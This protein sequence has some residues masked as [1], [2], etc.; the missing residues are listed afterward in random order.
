MS[1]KKPA[2][3]IIGLKTLSLKG[4]IKGQKY[5][6]TPIPAYKKRGFTDAEFQKMLNMNDLQLVQKLLLGKLLV[7]RLQSDEIMNLTK[8]E[9]KAV[10]SNLYFQMESI[11]GILQDR[12]VD[13]SNLVF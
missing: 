9:S 6:S 12:G 7:T 3:Q 10:A 11:R 8:K 13:V 5:V 4:E 1:N 2:P